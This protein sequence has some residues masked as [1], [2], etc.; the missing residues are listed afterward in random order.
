MSKFKK[1]LSLASAELLEETAWKKNTRWD[2]KVSCRQGCFCAVAENVTSLAKKKK[3]KKPTRELF[4][5]G[6][7]DFRS[8]DTHTITLDTIDGSH[9]AI[10]FGIKL[11]GHLSSSVSVEGKQIRVLVCCCIPWL[12]RSICLGVPPFCEQLSTHSLLRLSTVSDPSSVHSLHS[13]NTFSLSWNNFSSVTKI[14]YY[15]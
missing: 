2:L 12:Y 11:L 15:W 8:W 14:A 3:K 5:E 1:R 6:L 13:L 9:S 7:S 10:V 4:L